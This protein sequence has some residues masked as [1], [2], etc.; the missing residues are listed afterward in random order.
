MAA[1]SS[2]ENSVIV[3]L[4]FGPSQQASE[5]HGCG[6][7]GLPEFFVVWTHTQWSKVKV[8]TFKTVRF[9]GGLRRRRWVVKKFATFFPLLH[10]HVWLWSLSPF[11]WQRSLVCAWPIPTTVRGLYRPSVS[12]WGIRRR[13]EEGSQGAPRLLG[14]FLQE[15]H[16]NYAAWDLVSQRC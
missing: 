6:K 2:E 1:Y 5:E 14:I 16:L 7:I 8:K 4:A 12:A 15:K 9:W 11:V 3:D 10:R 13:L